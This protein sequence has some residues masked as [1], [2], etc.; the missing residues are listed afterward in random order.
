MP[1]LSAATSI[2]F[3]DIETVSECERFDE[4]SERSQSLWT[5]KA[6]RISSDMS[7]DEAYANRAGIFAEYAKVV[8]ISVGFLHQVND[9]WKLKLKSF[10]GDDEYLLLSDFA[11]FLRDKV[12]TTAIH[13]LCGHNIREFDIP[14]LCRRM[15]I[16]RIDIPDMIDLRDTKPWERAH[17][18]DTLQSWKFGDY[19]NYTSL[20]TLCNVFG[21]D[22]P[23]DAISG[24]DVHRVYYEDDD[25]SS[26][27]HYCEKDVFAVM[28]VYLAM[29][30]VIVDEEI[31]PVSVTFG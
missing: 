4:L 18:I 10:Y 15:L 28:Q 11:S 30:N 6:K 3:F 9:T 12:P 24:A 31:V 25:L 8:C 27:V 7:A 19:K 20:D 23:K 1:N 26:I 2:L 22:S 29:Y 16:N 5:K 21:I 14:F 13:S 17:I